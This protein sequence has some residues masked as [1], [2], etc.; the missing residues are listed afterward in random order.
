MQT[1][2]VNSTRAILSKSLRLA[3]SKLAKQQLGEMVTGTATASLAVATSLLLSKMVATRWALALVQPPWLRPIYRGWMR[4]GL[5]A[6]RV[7][8]PLVLGIVY[9]VMI[10]PM[11]LVMRLLGKDP[12]Q[13]TLDPE[14]K[15]YRTESAKSPREKLEKPF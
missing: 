2:T 5:L 8:T 14:R 11:A 4:F 15:S 13:R 9:F 1:W 12:L 7:V 6:S 3:N 10:S